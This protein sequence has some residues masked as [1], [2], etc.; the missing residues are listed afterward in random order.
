VKRREKEQIEGKKKKTILVV[1]AHKEERKG[2]SID[3]E[4]RKQWCA[5]LQAR[6]KRGEQ[7]G[8][9][10]SWWTRKEIA[11]GG[12]RQSTLLQV[13]SEKEEKKETGA[14]VVLWAMTNK[15]AKR[16]NLSSEGKGS[17]TFSP[18]RERGGT[19]PHRR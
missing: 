18:C 14:S 10:I 6:K 19:G 9:S 8:I 7:R 16:K 13:F 4:R 5:H 3:Q 11:R 2:S 12:G 15:Q 1:L 17:N